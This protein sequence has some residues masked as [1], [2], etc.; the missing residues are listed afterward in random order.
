MKDHFKAAVKRYPETERKTKIHPIS[1]EDAQIMV[2]IIELFKKMQFTKAVEILEK[3]KYE[4]D[5]DIALNLLDLNTEIAR[6]Q[7]RET[8]EEQSEP[9]VPLFKRYLVTCGRR[10]DMYLIIG[11]DEVDIDIETESGTKDL[12]CIHLNPTPEKVKSVP[13][14]A[15]EFLEYHTKEER[16]EV[17]VKMDAFME[18][19]R[20]LFLDS[21]KEE[22]KV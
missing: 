11:Y 13:F 6:S 14:Y 19:S 12:Y 22:T 10:I 3:W 18:N 2:E 9:K 1:E 21:D 15:N 7:G 16:Q 20:G 4:C 5:E 8:V 17:L